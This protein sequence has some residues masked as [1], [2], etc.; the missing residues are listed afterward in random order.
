[1][2]AD[3]GWDGEINCELGFSRGERGAVEGSW[4]IVLNFFFMLFALGLTYV[5]LLSIY[6]LSKV[7]LVKIAPPFQL[8]EKTTNLLVNTISFSSFLKLLF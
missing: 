3:G 1:M 5:Y 6:V 2:G 4:D 8:V 7:E